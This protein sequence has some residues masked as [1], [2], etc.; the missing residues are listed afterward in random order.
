MIIV[1]LTDD[2]T[3][4]TSSASLLYE[5]GLAGIQLLACEDL[6]QPLPPAQAYIVNVASR[7]VDEALAKERLRESIR[8]LK[9]GLLG[10]QV[11]WGKRI[12]STL[13]GH[14][15]GEL[16]TLHAELTKPLLIAPAFPQAGRSTIGG[17]QLVDGRLVVGY[18]PS[19]LAGLDAELLGLHGLRA[20]KKPTF[21]KTVIADAIE[22]ADLKALAESTFESW[23]AGAI[24][25]DS[26]PYLAQLAAMGLARGLWRHSACDQ[27]VDLR[28]HMEA[29]LLVQVCPDVRAPESE[30]AAPAGSS[31][32]RPAARRR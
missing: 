5:A 4:A 23:L 28:F 21:F 6:E 16:K 22:D 13:R 29:K 9:R 14:I 18:L 19:L 8:R 7:D 30:V 20:G 3:G 32:V 31:H 26:G 2:L 17:Y 24:V 12:D 25:I 11:L 27:V 15:A 10:K 1:Y